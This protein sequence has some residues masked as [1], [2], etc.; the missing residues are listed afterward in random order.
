MKS[1]VKGACLLALGI[2]FATQAA[3]ELPK[4]VSCYEML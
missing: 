2:P 3:D 4:T 1:L